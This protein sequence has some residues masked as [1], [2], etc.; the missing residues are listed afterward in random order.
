M[1]QKV[2]PTGFRLGVNKGW[3]SVSFVS[4]DR[5]ADSLHQDLAIRE[6]IEDKLK[7]AGVV[8][9]EIKRSMNKI[10]IE[11]NVARPGVVIGRGGEGIEVVKKDLRKIAHSPVDVKLFEVK[12]PEASAKLIG[13]NIASQL[14]RRVVPKFAAQREINN[15]KGVQGVKGI[16]IWVSGRIK[17]A[18]IARTEKFHWGSVPLQT[19]RAD[20]DYCYSCCAVPNAGIHGIKVWVYKGEI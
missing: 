14:V 7:S 18:E 5:Y 13:Q 1:A 4:K 17:G 3:Q 12:Q 11:I 16:R 8:V 19:L 10:E 9:T 15:I 20:I 6:Y 2:N